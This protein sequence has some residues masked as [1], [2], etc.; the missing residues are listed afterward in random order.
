[1]LPFP[2]FPT[3]AELAAAITQ[4][5]PDSWHDDPHGPP[6][7]RARVSAV[8]AEQIRSELSDTE[9]SDTELS[10]TASSAVGRAQEA[11]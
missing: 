9:L 1:M 7:W 5:P 8:L 11:S 6:D 4:V 3:A 2:V 10:E